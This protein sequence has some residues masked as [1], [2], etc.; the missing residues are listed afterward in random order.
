M[1]KK[2]SEEMPAIAI[3]EATETRIVKFEVDM[4]THKQL[5]MAV[6]SDGT[7]IVAYMKRLLAEDLKRRQK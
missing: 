4:E 1:A 2:R 3:P 5:R 6:A 7:T